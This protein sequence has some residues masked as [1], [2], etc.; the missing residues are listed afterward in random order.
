MQKDGIYHHME[1][2]EHDVGQPFLNYK[3]SFSLE[4][5]RFTR[6]SADTFCDSRS[7]DSDSCRLVSVD[8]DCR[9]VNFVVF[10]LWLT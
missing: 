6:F 5:F 4:L 7:D 9:L 10:V 8:T 3:R 1:L 2:H